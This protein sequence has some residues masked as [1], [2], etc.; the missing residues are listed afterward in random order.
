MISRCFSK[1][2]QSSLCQLFPTGK[3]LRHFQRG[4]GVAGELFGIPLF[5]R[6]V[7]FALGVI[8]N[9]AFDLVRLAGICDE[10]QRA[11]TSGL[12]V[13]AGFVEVVVGDYEDILAVLVDAGGVDGVGR[14]R[15]VYSGEDDGAFAGFPGFVYGFR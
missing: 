13:G 10:K 4:G 11:F 14:T 7:N 5:H 2:R 15:V 12:G 6:G 8:F 3:D 9:S 1:A